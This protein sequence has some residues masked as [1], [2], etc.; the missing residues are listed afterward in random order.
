MKVWPT[1]DDHDS[2]NVSFHD[3]MQSLVGSGYKPKKLGSRIH[4]TRCPMCRRENYLG[5]AANDGNCAW[6]YFDANNT[7]NPE[8]IREA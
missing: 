8:I 6:C 2:E 5:G 7:E 1:P 3:D 4:I